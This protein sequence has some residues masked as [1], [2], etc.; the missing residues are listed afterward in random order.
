[1]AD[2]T[3]L[4]ISGDGMPPYSV[5]GISE[6]L[7]PVEPAFFDKYKLTLTCSDIESPAFDALRVGL[8]KRTVNGEL[9]DLAGR[10]STVTVDCISELAYKTSGGSPSR[11]VV[12][13][14]SRT[15]GDFTLY[16]PELTMG[17]VAKT[18]QTDEY[19]AVVA[20]TLEL[21]EI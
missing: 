19:G 17:V 11:T 8:W 2:E 4:V 18:Q 16:R 1:M 9:I 13:G 6:T 20:W 21:A 7:E 14:S 3:L 12:S 10:G 5:R 15:S